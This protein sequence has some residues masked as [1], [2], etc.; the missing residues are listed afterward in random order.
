LSERPLCIDFGQKRIGI[1]ATDYL[2]MAARPVEVVTATPRDA[3]ADRIAEIARDRESTILV[4]GLPV[5]MDGS[6]HDSDAEVRAFARRCE[7]RT[8]LAVEFVDERLSTVEAE[9]LMK[10]AGIRRKDQR[11]VVDMY[12][13]VVILRDWMSRQG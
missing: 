1:A 6:V 7:E 12:A 2:G 9:H 8:G 5:N 4:M 10:E 3:A 13:A 11:E